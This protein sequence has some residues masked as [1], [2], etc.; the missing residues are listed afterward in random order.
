MS[1][2]PRL[3]TSAISRPIRAD[4]RSSLDAHSTTRVHSR[5]WD[6][7]ARNPCLN[8]NARSLDSYPGT[9][10]SARKY[11][12]AFPRRSGSPSYRRTDSTSSEVGRYLIMYPTDSSSIAASSSVATAR[13]ISSSVGLICD[14]MISMFDPRFRSSSETN[15]LED[16]GA[17]AA[18][19]FAAATSRARRSFSAILDWLKRPF[20][21]SWSMFA[22]ASPTSFMRSNTVPRMRIAGITSQ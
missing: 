17:D 19:D 22:S 1:A 7:A 5:I 3:S 12:S 2:L 11:R 4:P 16:E 8:C 14:S 9:A 18:G 10:T 6:T 21:A 13:A 20:N 15:P